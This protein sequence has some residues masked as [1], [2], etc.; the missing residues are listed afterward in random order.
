MS[1]IIVYR[2]DTSANLESVDCPGIRKVFGIGRDLLINGHEI[3]T[4]LASDAANEPPISVEMLR[5]SL[6][7]RAFWRRQYAAVGI[8]YPSLTPRSRR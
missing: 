6:A 1:Y 7:S 4:I 3:V 5:K 8:D 2:P